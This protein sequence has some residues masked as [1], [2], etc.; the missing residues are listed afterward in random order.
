MSIGLPFTRIPLDAWKLE[1]QK[2]WSGLEVAAVGHPLRKPL[3]ADRR[4]H[5]GSELVLP[6]DSDPCLQEMLVGMKQRIRH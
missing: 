1:F 5:W 2:R 6:T 3:Q 4:R